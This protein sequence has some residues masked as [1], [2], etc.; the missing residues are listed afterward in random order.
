MADADVVFEDY[1]INVIGE[2]DDRIANALEEAAGEL[3]SQVKDNYRS[4]T[5]DTKNSFDHF[6]DESKQ[7]VT[8][9]SPEFNA[10]LEEFGTGEFALNKD[11]RKGAWYVPVE[12]VSGK[13]RPTFNG[14]VV[15]V[16][17]KGGQAYYK[18]NGK[19]PTRAF[20][21]AYTTKKNAIINHIKNT[22]KGM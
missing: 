22:F 12:K 9:G 17:G 5:G 1:S 13:S 15:V 18:T 21:N 16:Y 3:E 7:E 10:V 14:K 11:G 8:I 19:T 2:F 4:D 6:V 20:W